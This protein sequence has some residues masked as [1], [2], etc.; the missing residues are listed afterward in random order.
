MRQH[1]CKNCGKIYLTDKP[2][3]WYCP[4]CA[5]ASRRNVLCNRVCATCGVEFVGYPRSKYCPQCRVE[6]QKAANLRHNKNGT[7]RP[8]GSIDLCEHCGK[9]YIVKG[10]RQRYC[11][12]CAKQVVAENI[13]TSKREY[14]QQHREETMARKAEMRKDRRI[15][16][17]CGNPFSANT[18]TVT[19]SPKCMEEYR[20]RQQAITD[21]RRGKAVPERTLGKKGRTNPQSGIPGITWHKGKWQLEIKGKYIGLFSTIEEAKAK[22]ESAEENQS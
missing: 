5:A 19:C 20:R 15:C 22:K 11:P 10:S 13:R 17:V 3:S 14:A 18:P 21:V 16:A 4:G 7:A 12:E 1:I 2:D 6:A 8:I 9:E